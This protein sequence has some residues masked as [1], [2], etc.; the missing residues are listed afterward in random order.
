MFSVVIF[1]PIIT[2]FASS[3]HGKTTI[4]LNVSTYFTTWQRRTALIEQHLQSY[5]E[6]VR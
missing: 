5:E 3:R 2:I 4:S 6:T 1:S